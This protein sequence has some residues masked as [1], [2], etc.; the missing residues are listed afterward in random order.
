[1]P[2]KRL[3]ALLYENVTVFRVSKSLISFWA[4]LADETEY[5][6][7]RRGDGTPFKVLYDEAPYERG[8]FFRLQVNERVG[9]LLVEVFKRVG[10][11]SFGSVKWPN[12]L[13]RWTPSQARGNV[14]FLDLFLFK[15]GCN[16]LKGYVKGVPFISDTKG[17]PFP[18]KMVYKRVR[19]G[20]RAEPA[21]TKIC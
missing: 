14:L 7:S 6:L 10:N 21:H 20:P 18:W 13:N 1:M 4:S 19:V 2:P 15:F 17:V 8:S 3:L 11:L 16:V 9:V 5:K 12:G